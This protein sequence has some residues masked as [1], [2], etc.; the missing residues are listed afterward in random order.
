MITIKDIATQLNF[1]PTTVSRAMNDENEVGE[2][3][4][5]KIPKKL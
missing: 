4:K 2:A 5:E 3:L 1:S